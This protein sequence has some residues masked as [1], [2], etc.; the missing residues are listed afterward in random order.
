LPPVRMLLV[1]APPPRRSKASSAAPISPMCVY[2]TLRVCGTLRVQVLS[3]LPP[4]VVQ[5]VLVAPS[6]LQARLLAA[7]MASKVMVGVE[8]ACDGHGLQVERWMDGPSWGCRVGMRLACDGWAD[9]H[10]GWLR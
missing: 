8:P 7:F 3:D 10:G 6:E 4:K 9:E 2:C 5:D 1:L